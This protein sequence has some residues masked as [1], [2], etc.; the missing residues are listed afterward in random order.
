MIAVILAA[1]EWE[2]GHSQKKYCVFLWGSEKK[3]TLS[4]GLFLNVFWS[5]FSCL[6]NF[7]GYLLK[8]V[9]VVYGNRETTMKL[10]NTLWTCELRGTGSNVLNFLLAFWGGCFNDNSL[11]YDNIFNLLQKVTLD[12]GISWLFGLWV[13]WYSARIY[14]LEECCT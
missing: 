3:V 2:C 5:Y 6:L 8:F 10:C 12:L 14:S 9:A 1:K 11:G 7:V 4:C 13:V